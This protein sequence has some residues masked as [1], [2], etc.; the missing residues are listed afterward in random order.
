MAQ[1][2]IGLDIGT[3]SIKAAV[4]ES[5]LRS[6]SLVEVAEHHLPRGVDG[7]L[8][9]ADRTSSLQ[10][11][12]R[13]I[14]PAEAVATAVAGRYAMTRELS[15]PFSDDKKI[16]TVLGF[17]LE[18]L[19]PLD[20]DQL[21]Y[22]YEPLEQGPDGANLLCAAVDKAWFS[23]FLAELQAADIDPKVVTLDAMAYAHLL[24]S[25]GEETEAEG[26]VA[27]VDVG[28]ETTSVTV[29][30]GGRVRTART[31]ARG[32]HHI[33]MALMKGLEVDYA[34][35]ESIKHTRLRIDGHLPPDVS[36]AEHAQTVALASAPVNACIRDIRLTLHAHANRWRT[37]VDRVLVFGGAS[38]L[39]GFDA[40]LGQA[41]GVTVESPRLSNQGWTKMVLPREQERAMPMAAALGL[42][43]VRGI[44][45]GINFRKGEFASESD[46]KALRERAGWLL[47]IAALLLCTFFAR[48]VVSLR[49]LESNHGALVSQLEDFSKA[50]LGEK[51]DDF[52]FVLQRL[53]R[54][55]AQEADSIFPELTAFRTFYD[56]TESQALINE[57][58]VPEEGT[59]PGPPTARPPGLRPPSDGSS[60]DE[61]LK[62]HKAQTTKLHNDVRSRALES[63]AIK[64]TEGMQL[65]P[66]T[67]AIPAPRL[68]TPK[69]PAPVKEA[70]PPAPK[71]ISGE[72]EGEEKSEDDGQ[73]RVELKHVEID[74]KS[75]FVKGEANNIEAIE[76]FTGEL[77][78]HRCFE[79]VETSDTTRL[80]FGDRQDWLRFQLKVVIDCAAKLGD[81]GKTTK[82]EN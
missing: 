57:M 24:A 11:L 43:F 59:A 62:W 46:F 13:E 36:E 72:D 38:R 31:I 58:K 54:P 2:V 4:L 50:V 20:I 8:L 26:C 65:L 73:Y 34:R 76:A 21:V 52:D 41:L 28:H 56:I 80:S 16:A 6:F 66:G 15:L 60:P 19:L 35:A 1:T 42:G 71:E 25:L 69:R 7:N 70:S 30:Q 48:Q 74:L 12:F 53:N 29:V 82:E 22:D 45:D 5:T 75:A 18:E 79:T 68:V 78:K 10:A 55:P 33:T 32:G 51:K 3:W 37:R 9:N 67:S 39:P 44:R 17:E 64:R 49:M 47:T 40:E 81:E 27:L 14:R 23:G 63:P 77:K 61:V